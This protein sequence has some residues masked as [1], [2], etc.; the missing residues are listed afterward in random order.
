V[1]CFTSR[2]QDCAEQIKR[3]EIAVEKADRAYRKGGSL[4]A[5]NTA[6]AKLAALHNRLYE[7]DGGV[8]RDDR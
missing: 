2:A 8:V 3:Q 4:D 1:T 6:N 7:I 5:V